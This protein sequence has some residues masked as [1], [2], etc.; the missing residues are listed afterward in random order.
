MKEACERIIVAKQ[1][2]EKVTVYGDYDDGN[3]PR[4]IWCKCGEVFT[5]YILHAD[6][7]VMKL[8][9]AE[10]EEKDK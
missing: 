7:V 9:D 4:E 8:F 6:H 3:G 5:A 2:G 1:L 10:D